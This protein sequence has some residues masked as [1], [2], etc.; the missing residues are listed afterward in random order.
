MTAEEIDAKRSPRGGWTAKTLAEWGISWP[1]PR[2]WRKALLAGNTPIRGRSRKRTRRTRPEDPL[3]LARSEMETINEA[4]ISS[5]QRGKPLPID[6][7]VLVKQGFICG[8]CGQKR[9]RMVAL[10]TLVHVSSEMPAKCQGCA[11]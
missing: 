9:A 10:R 6:Y 3:R 7:G 2:G 5:A 8:G 11:A 1:P 4:A